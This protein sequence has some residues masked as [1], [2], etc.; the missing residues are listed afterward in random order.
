MSPLQLGPP[1]L[2]DSQH[3]HVYG[4]RL[5]PIKAVILTVVVSSVADNTRRVYGTALF[6]NIF[7][8]LMSPGSSFT[9][10][11]SVTGHLLPSSPVLE[12]H[13]ATAPTVPI[14]THDEPD[15]DA[16]PITPIV[17]QSLVASF[18]PSTQLSHGD[19]KEYR[20]TL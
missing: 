6:L 11:A 13:L 18:E 15:L 5:G 8:R 19:A 2:R 10:V 12:S 17:S 16:D 1:L 14:L 20:S 3:K 9:I 7:Y 4:G